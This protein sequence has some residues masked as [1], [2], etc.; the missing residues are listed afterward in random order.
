M[1]V[2]WSTVTISTAA[3]QPFL[4]L[5]PPPPCPPPLPRPL[6]L[7]LCTASLTIPKPEKRS[8][9]VVGPRGNSVMAPLADVNTGVDY[10]V[11][12]TMSEDNIVSSFR[13]FLLKVVYKIMHFE[14][15]FSNCR[16]VFKVC[17]LFCWTLR[18]LLGN[19]LINNISRTLKGQQLLNLKN[20]IF[21]PL[22]KFPLS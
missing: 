19:N 21:C 20:R 11:R 6:L 9:G 4:P 18:I 8:Y 15:F 13:T 10:R 16:V 22:E 7:P 14:L 3:W 5:S 2:R 12:K 17:S 1:K